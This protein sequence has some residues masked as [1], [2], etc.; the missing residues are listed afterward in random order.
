MPALGVYGEHLAEVPSGCGRNLGSRVCLRLLY[1][2]F[3]VVLTS[4][5][6]QRIPMQRSAGVIR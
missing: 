4:V 5:H 3:V 2:P 6:W 1:A